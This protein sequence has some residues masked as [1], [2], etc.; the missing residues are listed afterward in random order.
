M[1]MRCCIRR[2]AWQAAY[3][4]KTLRSAHQLR[5]VVPLARRYYTSQDNA[6]GVFGVFRILAPT[7]ILGYGFPK[8][9]FDA[10]LDQARFDLI[11]VD[12]GS[13]DPG[14]YYLASRSSFTSLEHVLRDLQIIV[15]GMGKQIRAGHP[16]KLVVGSAGGCGT[17]NQVLILANALRQMMVHHLPEPTLATITSEILDLGILEGRSLTPLGPMPNVSKETLAASNS[18]VVAQMGLEPIM[19]ALPHSD[20]VLCGRAYDP[21]LFAAEPVRRGFPAAIALH[22]AKI[23]ECGAIATTPGSGSDCLAAEL[24][25]DGAARFWAPN[26]K[27]RATPM[28][29]SAHTLYEKS[30][31]HCFGLPGGVLKT[32]QSTFTAISPS[33][34]EVLGT[35]LARVAPAVKLEGARMLGPQSVKLELGSHQESSQDGFV[36]GINGVEDRP[37]G[38]GEEE[39]GIV[40][41][42]S[43]GSMDRNKSHLALLRASLLHWGFEGRTATAGNLAFP[44]SPS[45]LQCEDGFL[46][47]CGTRDPAF[48]SQWPAIQQN[49]QD[50]VSTLSSSEGLTI[51]FISAG[52]QGLPRLAVMKVSDGFKGNN[53][54]SWRCETMA[55]EYTLQHLVDLDDELFRHLFAIKLWR[56]EAEEVEQIQPTLMSWGDGPVV[57]LEEAYKDWTRSCT[58]SSSSCGQKLGKLARV[59]RSKNAGINEITFDIIFGD[60]DGYLLAKQSPSLDIDKVG[61]MLGRNVLGVYCDDASRALKITCERD[62]LAGSPGDKDVYGAQQHRKLLDLVL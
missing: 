20:I 26:E 3:W 54:S 34:V 58:S 62:I 43:G 39:L 47:V 52:L 55:A 16:C 35:E 28:S 38:D 25:P 22:A 13:I 51:R 1:E 29:I 59:V 24:Y 18:V 36:Y 61:P 8:A 41:I 2:F 14:P 49:V 45:D 9:S 15:E 57:S 31:P 60:N 48:I 33:V 12:A 37:L 19:S 10:A 46:T 6:S 32:K 56:A 42:V 4:E 21:A 11:A 7:A 53:T 5:P 50:Y 23:L 40:I 30:H 27:R 44:F 17:N